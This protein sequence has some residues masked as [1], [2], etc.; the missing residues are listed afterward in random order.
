MSS[1]GP[2]QPHALK[3]HRSPSSCAATGSI[4][5]G[6]AIQMGQAYRP[7][8]LSSITL[9]LR[10]SSIGIRVLAVYPT[11]IA[12]EQSIRSS[13]A[14]LPA[15]LPMAEPLRN[16]E[17]LVQ[18]TISASDPSGI[19]RDRCL[20]ILVGRS[21][22]PASCGSRSASAGST[23]FELALSARGIDRTLRGRYE[24]AEREEVRADR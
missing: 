15:V 23:S 18:E 22:W 3:T 8:R 9:P 17:A 5:P 11:W 10:W 12:C 19:V 20:V 16:G 7:G 14:R 4:S 6:V 2:A 21:W 1:V 24:L 13:G